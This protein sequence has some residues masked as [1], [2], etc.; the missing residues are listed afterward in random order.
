LHNNTGEY[1]FAVFNLSTI[2]TILGR[3]EQLKWSSYNQQW[4]L[5]KTSDKKI[6]KKYSAKE[7]SF[8]NAAIGFFVAVLCDH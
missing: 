3:Q 7:I 6:N 1:C 8:F 2:G 5:Y 4:Q